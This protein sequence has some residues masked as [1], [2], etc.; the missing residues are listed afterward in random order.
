MS[1]NAS[2]EVTGYY[3]VAPTVA[4]GFLREADGTFAPPSMWREGF[5]PSRR[6]SMPRGIL[7]GS[8][9]CRRGFRKAFSGTPKGRFIIFDPPHR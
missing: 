8:T 5:G 6:A 7:P 4:R 9:S 1:I 2:M 3:Y